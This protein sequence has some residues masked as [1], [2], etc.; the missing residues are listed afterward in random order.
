MST[1]YYRINRI[2]SQ[3]EHTFAMNNAVWDYLFGSDGQYP[4]GADQTSPVAV[5]VEVPRL[6][7]LM[8]GADKY[9]IRK[10][11]EMYRH[12][13]MELLEYPPSKKMYNAALKEIRK[14]PA[15]GDRILADLL[16]AVG[17]EMHLLSYL[18]G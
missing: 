10:L 1:I 15:L 7:M 9:D 3:P 13:L 4:Q 16:F 8:K 5:N 6:A 14:D 11:P 12:D 2:V 17:H 18:V